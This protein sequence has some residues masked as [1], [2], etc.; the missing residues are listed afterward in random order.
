MNTNSDNT[1]NNLLAVNIEITPSHT[2]KINTTKQLPFDPNNQEEYDDEIQE[3]EWIELYP[4]KKEYHFNI[5]F[6][7]NEIAKILGGCTEKISLC[8]RYL[9]RN[10]NRN[11]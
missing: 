8:S 6:N 9:L 5:S 1:H 2:I 4:N 11:L 10:R 3:I 7:K